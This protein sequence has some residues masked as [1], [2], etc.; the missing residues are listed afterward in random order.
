MTDSEKLAI[1]AHLHVLL[2]RKTG[3]VTDVEW[4]IR[5]PEYAQ[6]IIRIALAE[7]DP[8]ELSDWALKLQIAIFVKVNSRS[9]RSGG[10][11]SSV[12]EPHAS[13]NTATSNTDKRP[14]GSSRYVGRLR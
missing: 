9:T 1:A 13:A 14:E 8:P 4:L 7:A 2:R 10:S 5:S 12:T 6:E 3:R 11:S